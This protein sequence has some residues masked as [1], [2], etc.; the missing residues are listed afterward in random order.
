[1]VKV[2][3]GAPHVP[4]LDFIAF[5][6]KTYTPHVFVSTMYMVSPKKATLEY[7]ALGFEETSKYLH[8]DVAVLWPMAL[9]EGAGK[10][11]IVF[12][13]LTC[14]RLAPKLFISDTYSQPAESV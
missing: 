3:E 1:M 5:T 14:S 6:L 4:R 7:A 2:L 8:R 9:A 12:A 13:K 10:T 11:S